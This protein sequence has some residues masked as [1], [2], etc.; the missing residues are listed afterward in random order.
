MAGL[1]ALGFRAGLRRRARRCP[2]GA[3][4]RLRSRRMDDVSAL[5]LTVRPIGWIETPWR[6]HRR[7]PAQRPRDCSR[8]RSA[9]P[10]CCPEYADGLRD[11]EGFSH[12]ILLYWMHQGSGPSMTVAPSATAGRTGC[13]PPARRAARTRSRS[14]S[15]AFEGLRR[16]AAAPRAQ[17]RLPER[18]AADRHQALYRAHRRRTRRRGWAGSTRPRSE[19]DQGVELLAFLPTAAR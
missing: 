16:P 10:C 15:C 12:L 19:K 11:I 1:S 4:P 17:P 9:M 2:A 18:H 14:R 13:S 5:T 8:R 6:Q 3:L 7:M